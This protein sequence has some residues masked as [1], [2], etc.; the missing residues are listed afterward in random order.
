MKLKVKKK[1]STV[2][3]NPI[4]YGVDMEADIVGIEQQLEDGLV[5]IFTR[6]KKLDVVESRI[7]P[8][9]FYFWTNSDEPL[10][11]DLWDDQ[12][13]IYDLDQN[14]PKRILHFDTLVETPNVKLMW[15]FKKNCKKGNF[16]SIR[17]NS[18]FL[19]HTG[20]TF[21]K[22]MDF[23]DPLRMY[24]DIETL[25]TLG[26]KFTNPARVNDKVV[27]I[28]VTTNRNQNYLLFLN[29]DGW[30]D[31][32]TPEE[33]DDLRDFTQANL[34]FYDTEEELLQGFIDL[35]HI[36]DPD[37]IANHNIF[38]F[39]L[40]FMNER[41]RFHD[42][43]LE[44]GR[45]HEAPNIFPATV[46]IGE[47]K[48]EITCFD[49]YGRSIIDTD[50]LARQ[51]D[52]VARK[53]ENYR[54]KYLIKTIGH[55][56]KG[57]IIIPGSRITA[58]WKNEDPEFS[59]LDL[60]KYAMD[61][62]HD[63]K[64]LDSFFGRAVFRSTQ[65]TP[66]T[67]QDTFRLA[68]GGKAE[69]LFVRHYYHMGHALA[70]PQKYKHI[71][72]GLAKVLKFGY[73][74]DP[75]TLGDVKSMY[76]SLAI[77]LNIQPKNDVLGFFQIIV[78]LLREFRYSIKDQLAD[79]EPDSDEYTEI[80]STD[81]AIKIYLNTISYGYL[82]SRFGLFADFD[83]A[84]RITSEEEGGRFMLR[85][86][87]KNT[88]DLGGIPIKCDTDG[89]SFVAP[90]GIRGNEKKERAFVKKLSDMM[91]EGIEIG[92]D[93]RYKRMMTVDGK[94][95]ALIDYN[96]K[97]TIKGDTLKSRRKEN[98]VLTHLDTCVR[99]ILQNEN[100]DILENS[101]FKWQDKIENSKLIENEIVQHASLNDPL[102]TYVEKVKAG[103]GNGGRNQS[104]PYEVALRMQE[105]GQDMK[106][107]DRVEYYVAKSPRT[108]QL[109]KSGK[110]KE[111]PK[112][113]KV[114]ELAENIEKF[115]PN[116]IHKKHYIKR[117]QSSSS[118]LY[119]LFYSQEDLKKKFGIRL[120]K[121]KREK[122]ENEI[123]P[124]LYHKIY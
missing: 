20:K 41:C 119:M 18:M 1:K 3:Y 86:M 42:I 28:S 120:E 100:F 37:V 16:Y 71:S 97:I 5:E 48:R 82:A 70:S 69:S 12:A 25:T 45:N 17:L 111:K 122:L 29:D 50:V 109:M 77:L 38:N 7:E 44:I 30:W 103:V 51:V 83:E 26:Y 32:L 11:E 99:E 39:D 112:Y 96:D 33:Q 61:D 2:K 10:L 106:V 110:I 67:Y 13:T 91:P 54:L 57:R 101:F 88:E 93:G 21:F 19:N 43:D 47:T 14:D 15:W 59:R 107:G 89:L 95:Y 114:F 31:S 58:A 94:S 27:I 22:G 124:N 84:Q 117:L 8:S 35:V 56:R 68:S 52:H 90:E 66:Y 118:P 64:T 34:K 98:F 40:W 78:K 115:E 62:A 73:V 87:I 80:K 81:G 60:L 76:P 102:E 116:K 6:N 65:F 23:N 121:K 104:A 63:A 92:V 79:L 55:E 108:L 105:N 75:I 53:Y 85:L 36:I 46:S 72:G 123:K 74:K 24:F 9:N 113:K 4:L 49:V